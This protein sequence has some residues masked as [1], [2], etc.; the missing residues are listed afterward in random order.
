V[1]FFDKLVAD[2]PPALRKLNATIR[3]DLEDGQA[4]RHWLLTMDHGTVKVA[5]RKAPAD[6][7]ICTDL[8]LF[9]RLVTGEANAMAA[10]LRGQV[11]I[12]GD[13]ELLVAFQRLMPGP[14]K[15]SGEDQA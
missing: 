1:D 7:V 6:A 14:P 15:N 4:T 11:R 8:G 10:T 3:F 9:Q 5:H 13:R 2:P 12:E